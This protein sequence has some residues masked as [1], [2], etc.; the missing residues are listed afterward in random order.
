MTVAE[1]PKDSGQEVQKKKNGAEVVER[2]A[3]PVVQ[4]TLEEKSKTAV[5]GFPNG[6]MEVKYKFLE[7]DAEG[8]PTVPGGMA[9]A[10]LDTSW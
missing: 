3:Y 8:L 1:P 10:L 5:V 2:E 4:E 9:A 7:K 6:T